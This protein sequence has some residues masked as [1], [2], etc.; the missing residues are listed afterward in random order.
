MLLPW[1]HSGQ[2]RASALLGVA[3]LSLAAHRPLLCG[4]PTH[5]VCVEQWS[6]GSST[7]RRETLRLYYWVS[8]ATECYD[9]S[10][11]TLARK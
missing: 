5:Y 9:T 10:G 6:R 7:W 8:S 3:G 2:R 4:G 11:E 1:E